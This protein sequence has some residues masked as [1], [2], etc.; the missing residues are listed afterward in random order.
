MSPPTALLTA[1]EAAEFLRIRPATLAKYRSVGG[2]PSFSKIGG[3]IVYPRENLEQWVAECR[4]SS[5]S[6]YR[7]RKAAAA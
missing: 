7:S 3:R 4:V 2:G 1:P 5:T 6:E